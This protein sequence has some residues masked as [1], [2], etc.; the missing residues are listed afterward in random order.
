MTV[1]KKFCG[2]LFV[3]SMFFVVSTGA[4]A[5]PVNVTFEGTATSVSV[6]IPG[7]QVGDTW[8]L[9]FVVDNG[10]TDLLSETWE[11][12]DIVGIVAGTSSG[13]YEATYSGT[14]LD[15]FLQTDASGLFTNTATFS[16]INSI[17]NTDNVAGAAGPI[18]TTVG[19]SADNGGFV[20][21]TSTTDESGWNVA[22]ADTGGGDVPEP[23]AI[24]ILGV[25]LVGLALMR[26]RKPKAT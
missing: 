22:L 23:G 13:G 9:S 26:R 17:G 7:L 5:V 16:D 1:F 25:G 21:I 14:G 8:T 11:Q 3:V 4:N 15:F 19:P 12:G 20:F 18:Y 6:A 24:A 2:G 10:G